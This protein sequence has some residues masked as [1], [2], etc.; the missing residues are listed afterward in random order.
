MPKGKAFKGFSDTQMKRIAEK[1][2]YNGPVS[3]FKKFLQSN[4]AM[5]N[6]FTGLEEKARMKFAVGG[7]MG[8]FI[9]KQNKVISEAAQNNADTPKP[10][11]V[12]DY[13]RSAATMPMVPSGAMQSP[14]TDNRTATPQQLQATGLFNKAI[15]QQAQA[16]LQPEYMQ[17]KQITPAPAG[18]DPAL[19]YDPS[20]P[21][22]G[23]AVTTEFRT[24]EQ[25]EALRKSIYQSKY[26]AQ[27]QPAQSVP[28]AP[29][30]SPFQEYQKKQNEYMEN[31]LSQA[32]D[33]IKNF[34][35]RQQ[36]AQKEISEKYGA[37]G[38]Q[39]QDIFDSKYK[40]RLEA[41]TT[42]E[43]RKAIN[44]EI[45]ADT[46]FQ[47]ARQSYEK[48]LED[49]PLVQEMR[50]DTQAYQ[51]YM[52]QGAQAFEQ[53]NPAP[54]MTDVALQR[55]TQPGVPEGGQFVAE[56]TAQDP[57]QFVDPTT[58]Q[59]I[60]QISDVTAGTAPTS[61]A[62]MPDQ[63][64]ATTV[65]PT[66]AEESIRAEADKLQ[67][68]QGQVSEQA[69]VSAAQGE[70][71]SGA[72]A[73]TPKF[74]E[75]F[76]Q[77]V[78][79]GTREVADSELAKAATEDVAPQAE[80]AKADSPVGI[81][82]E[83]TAVK[84]EE[85]TIAAEI[86][87][88]KMAQAEVASAAG[89]DPAAIA[90]AEQMDSFSVDA[91]T[92]AAFKAGNVEAQATVQGQLTSLMK[93]FDDG[94]PEWAAGAIRQANAAMAARGMGGSSMAGA[95]IL[96]AA[97]ESALPIAQQDA[98]A[99]ADMGLQNASMQ[100]QVSLANAAAQQGVEIA[101]LNNRQ[102]TALQNSVNAFGLQTQNLS[103]AQQ[104]MISN[105]QIRAS[106]QG[107]NLNNRQQ[108]AIANAARFAD[109][110]NVNLNNRQQVA[111]QNSAESLQIDLSNLSNRQQTALANA[112]LQ[113]AL[114]GKNLDNQQQT[115]VINAEKFAEANNM[116]FTSGQQAQLQ[117]SEL[118]KTIGLANLNSEQASV[119]QNAATIAGMDMANL[120]N[121]QQAAVQNAQAF[122]QMD[123]TNLSN[124]QQTGIFKSQQIMQSILSDQSVENA[125][126][127]FNASSENQVN[128]FF[129]NMAAQI[130]Q[131]N[132]TQNNA[133]TQFNE[134]NDIDVQK[135]NTQI[136][137]ARDQFNAQNQLVIA[138]SN[139]QWHRDIA[140]ADT[141]AIN[142]S[143]EFNARSLLD[144]AD[145]AYNNL[146]QT[147]SDV[148]EYAW[149]SGESERSR[150]AD[151]TIAQLQADTTLQEAGI[152][153]DAANDRA[154]GGFVAR[155][156]FGN[157][158]LFG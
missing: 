125:A 128:Q 92:L 157:G 71:S 56:K 70:V 41:A 64:D 69:Q 48:M 143:N 44:D 16:T 139:A 42:Y 31:Y 152:T 12:A 145:Q 129:A 19:G 13:N 100:N 53:D 101:N 79:G 155:I 66:K 25:E 47:E 154:A 11:S 102:Q 147:Y 50:R 49:D 80:A 93:Q 153:Q 156:L 94:T 114:Q 109:V 116:T 86:S 61:Q 32:P 9:N 33:N 7:F 140:T 111:L 126:K 144:I 110:N 89:L 3:G 20:D 123:M 34:N 6:K 45:Q 60:G 88:A 132:A 87:E 51:E 108:A 24:P 120:N 75:Q 76:A 137:E 67:P 28:R 22:Q 77:K 73:G 117:N 105:A 83:Q 21:Y 151:L 99:F 122:L 141:A 106:L 130:N 38:Q 135:F 23:S 96:Q 65:D 158:G 150:M 5:A 52:L 115:A 146:W 59:L 104:T 15:Q 121:R 68:A 138:Q 43:E 85:L 103:N 112:Q 57:N 37:V 113:A 58:G 124:E 63:F 118:M 78:E 131:Y 46:E 55:M 84:A 29:A 95:A 14:P 90:K 54:T 40:E 1:L 35:S 98:K 4:P 134:G 142:A 26:G 119:L 30:T 2:G 74:D 62:A 91:G 81:T 36:A 10:T 39:V 107:I 27:Q 136:Q 72:I 148:M 82:A 17:G 8:N 97:M 127:Q 18:Y 133:M 149:K